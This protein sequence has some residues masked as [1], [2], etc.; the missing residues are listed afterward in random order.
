MDSLWAPSRGRGPGD[1]LPGLD[2]TMRRRPKR[3][4]TCSLERAPSWANRISEGEI[5]GDT[6]I[7]MLLRWTMGRRCARVLK[8]ASNAT[9]IRANA[10]MWPMMVL[11]TQA[12]SACRVTTTSSPIAVCA[13]CA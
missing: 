2:A 1:G 13:E 12:A 3:R 11:I 5:G 10:P 9:S 4:M 6:V 7:F 8:W